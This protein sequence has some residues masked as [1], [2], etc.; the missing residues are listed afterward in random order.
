MTMDDSLSNVETELRISP[1][2]VLAALLALGCLLFLGAE[3]LSSSWHT[4]SRIISLFLLLSSLSFTGW[5]LASWKPLM[6]RWFTVLALVTAVHLTGFWL[7]IPGSLAW[8]VIPT[9]LAVPLVGFPAAAIVAVGESGLVVV[10]AR[11]PAAGAAGFNSSSVSVVLVAIWAV[12]GAMVALYHPVRRR[13]AWSDEYFKRAQQ[14]LEEAQDRRAELEQ[15]LDDLAHANRQL[16]LM[17]ERITTL[18]LIAEEAQKAKTRFVARVSH[19]F[20]T[21]LNMIIG[22]V[23][24]MVESPEMYDVTLSPRM[25]ED[26]KTVHRNCEHL[27]D[28]VNDV[29]DL[30]RIEADRMVLHKE[31]VDIQSVIDSATEVVRPLLEG[32]QLA[33]HISI[34]EDLPEVYCDRT[35]IEQVILNLMSN[36]ARYTEEGGI[37]VAVARRDQHVLVSVTDTGPGIPPEDVERIFEPFCQGTSDLWR[38]KGGSGLGLSISKQFVELHG[39]RMRVESE[40]G[41]GTTFTFDLPISAP[42][43][44][45]SRPGHQIREEWIWHERQ[46]KPSFPESHYNFRLVTCDEMGDL[47]VWLKRYAAE[48]EIVDTRDLDQAIKTLQQTPAHAVL[49]NVAT[50]DSAWPLVQKVTQQVS[51]TPIIGCSVPHSFERARALGAL[52]YLIKPVTRANL[53][54]AL[55][56]VGHP[57]RRVLVVDDDPGALQLFSSILHVCDSTLEVV[58]AASGQEALDQLRCTPPDLVLLDVVMP[59]MDGWQVLEAM[60]RDGE[61]PKVPTFFVS[62]QDPSDQPPTSS[63]LLATMDKGLSLSKLL[64]CSLEISKLLLQPEGALDLVPG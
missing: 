40:L 61:M 31:R 10:L 28:M 20:R 43:A 58:T 11:Y 27:A 55:K 16:M 4:V 30:T 42:I 6:G 41:N 18:R 59:D 46:S 32:K 2:L 49:L 53:K 48:V 36:A 57:V 3:L 29:L 52:G 51:G 13:S 14:F 26:L 35:R 63:F 22:L 21:P 60:T 44:P 45:V 34:P 39:G 24:L 1:K 37:M 12:S 54:Q 19:E 23:D 38:D 64:R 9:A 50:P 62:A 17:N 56:A 5:L 7:D 8:A 47:P 33:L 15:A 25:R